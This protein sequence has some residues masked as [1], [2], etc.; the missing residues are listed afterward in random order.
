MKENLHSYLLLFLINNK[1]CDKLFGGV[2]RV[3]IDKGKGRLLRRENLDG[4]I[5]FVKQATKF[6]DVFGVVNC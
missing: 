2:G 1:V 3:V 6:K 4:D 5:K